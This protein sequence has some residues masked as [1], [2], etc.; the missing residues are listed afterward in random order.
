[1]DWELFG[2]PFSP[3]AKRALLEDWERGYDEYMARVRKQDQDLDRRLGIE[4][5]NG[6]PTRIRTWIP[7]SR[8]QRPTA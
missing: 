5:R 2:D 7:G 4:P 1:M 6:S 8:G 3:E